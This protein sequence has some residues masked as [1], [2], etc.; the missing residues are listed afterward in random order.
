MSIGRESPKTEPL[1]WEGTGFAGAAQGMAHEV[2]AK[3]GGEGSSKPRKEFQEGRRENQACQ[4]E[5]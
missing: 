5:A 1:T 2:R 3:P 4:E